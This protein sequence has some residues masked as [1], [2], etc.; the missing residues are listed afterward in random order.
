M[1]IALVRL[2]ITLTSDG[3][4][5]APEASTTELTPVATDGFD[6]AHTPG[7]S[8][9]GGLRAHL[10]T[11]ADTLMGPLAGTDDGVTAA[12]PLRVLGTTTG[13]GPAFE[14]G[15]T[16][17]DRTRGAATTNTLRRAQLL[18]A[19]TTI[20][21]YL[22]LDD[23]DQHW[24]AFADRLAGWRPYVGGGRSAGRG[25]AAVT[26]IG[27]RR[28][29][30]TTVDGLATWLDMDGPDGFDA[31]LTAQLTPVPAPAETITVGWEVAGALH[32]GTGD[33]TARSA[34][35]VRDGA[36]RPIVPGSSWKG[37]IRSR[38]EWI[39]HALG[40]QVCPHRSCGTCGCCRLF[41]Y[42]AQPGGRGPT[43]A[44][45]LIAFADS[46]LTTPGR[47]DPAVVAP[48][49]HV[50]IDRVTGGARDGLL[51]TLDTIRCAQLTLSITVTEPLQ[52]WM[53]PLLLLALRDIHDGYIGV[54]AATT[55]GYGTLRAVD[56]AQLEP[57][58]DSYAALTAY[59]EA[60]PR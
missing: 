59:T 9:A 27:Y 37:V 11:A 39:L 38:C 56:P 49:T 44:R 57:D 16:A 55:R 40:A 4:V 30:L 28:L 43:G 50:A 51:F 13:A 42:S 23:A 33:D 29:D 3:G 32:I 14:R 21:L 19:G 7:T 41:G 17:V 48:R 1:Q 18:P 8:L 60:N 46:P 2:D 10:G 12:S 35:L 5:R 15:Q 31:L 34:P 45:A 20:R 54:G 36:G 53:R 25:Q 6:A 24:Q 58:P 26:R 47:P 52:A 22:R